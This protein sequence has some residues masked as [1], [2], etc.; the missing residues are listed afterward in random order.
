MG[1]GVGIVQFGARVFG[2]TVSVSISETLHV[3]NLNKDEFNVR[4]QSHEP[5]TRSSIS[6]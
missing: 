5:R 6:A 2:E 3:S 4:E 1:V